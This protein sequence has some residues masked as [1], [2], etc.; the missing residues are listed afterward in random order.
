MFKRENLSFSEVIELLKNGYK[1][2]VPEWKGFWALESGK[3][4]AHCAN[5]EVVEAT[6][7]QINIFRNDWIVVE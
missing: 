4:M 3:V 6:H 5:G 2:A 7:F 1:V